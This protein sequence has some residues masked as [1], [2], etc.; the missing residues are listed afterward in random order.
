MRRSI[1]PLFGVASILEPPDAIS[2]RQPKLCGLP[3]ALGR[4]VQFAERLRVFR[5]VAAPD[6]LP[7]FTLKTPAPFAVFST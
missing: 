6:F 5:Q 7:D 4:K 3:I 2:T 1:Y